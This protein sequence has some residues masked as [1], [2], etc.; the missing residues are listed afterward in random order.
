MWYIYII[1]NKINNKVY[2]GQTRKTIKERF[3]GHLRM[4]KALKEEDNVGSKLYINMN[5]HV[6]ITLHI[7]D[8]DL[9]E[10]WYN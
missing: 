2:I 8:I 6:I 7:K 4:A 9:K 1:K 10:Y 3:T 5:K